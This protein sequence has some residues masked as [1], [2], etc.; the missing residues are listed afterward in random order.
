MKKPKSRSPREDHNPPRALAE[1]GWRYHH[2][3]VPTTTPRPGEVYLEEFKMYVS[4]FA[5]SPYGVEWMRFEAASPVSELIRTVPHIAF[6]V[7]DLESALEGKQI[8]TPPNSPSEGLRV[9]MIVHDGAP[10]ELMQFSAPQI[11]PAAT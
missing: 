8:L 3:G 11:S 9:A 4:G 6:V 5:T 1:W 2:I 7:D 10:I